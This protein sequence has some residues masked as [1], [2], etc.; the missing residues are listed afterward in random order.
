MP[1]IVPFAKIADF[2]RVVKTASDATVVDTLGQVKAQIA[3]LESHEKVLKVE[4]IKRGQLEYDGET[5]R[6]TV[7]RT[8][9]ETLR[10]A[11]VRA[12]LSRQFIA[13]NTTETPVTSV[14]VVARIAHPR[15]RAA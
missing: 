1:N 7:T 8:I 14:R 11:A 12:K 2:K 5:F 3:K 10:M 6:A 13:A 4:L 9:K 15:K